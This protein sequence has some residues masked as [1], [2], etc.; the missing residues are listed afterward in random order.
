MI[1][2]LSNQEF[3]NQLS[4][5]LPQLIMKEMGKLGFRGERN[6]PEYLGGWVGTRTQ[7]YAS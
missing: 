6:V 4:P 3:R 1:H 5:L 2:K 7:V